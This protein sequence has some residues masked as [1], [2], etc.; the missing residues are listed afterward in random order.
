MNKSNKFQI[1]SEL[2]DFADSFSKKFPKLPTGVF[3]SDKMNYSLICM[4]KI[5]R[6]NTGARIGKN[7][8]II[9]LDQ[10]ILS[11][12]SQDFVFIVIIWC[13]IRHIGFKEEEADLIAFE[14][15]K[16]TGR[17]LE[18]FTSGCFD[19]LERVPTELNK[20]RIKNI[21]QWLKTK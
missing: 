13:V 11:K 15:Y 21:L 6:S 7:S 14:Y 1:D 3:N 18:N 9:E 12:T 20:Q 17:K 16:T 8:S 10:S 2:I 5:G 19:I 4:K